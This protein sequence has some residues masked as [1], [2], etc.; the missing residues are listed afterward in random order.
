MS[1]TTLSA[2]SVNLKSIAFL[3]LKIVLAL[4]FLAAAG[5]KLAGVPMMVAEFKTVGLGQWFRYF[6]AIL[7]ITGAILLLLPGRAA[8]GALVL[9]V[10]CAGAFLA[11]VLAIHMDFV[12]TIILGAIFLAIAWSQRGQLGGVFGR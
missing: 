3:I 7:E 1:D 4:L 12:H 5:A 8:Y 9:A 10:V 6:V 2:K 11:Q